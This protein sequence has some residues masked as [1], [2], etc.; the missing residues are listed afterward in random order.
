MAAQQLEDFFRSRGLA[1][2]ISTFQD[3]K[4][5]IAKIWYLVRQRRIFVIAYFRLAD[6]LRAFG[7][8]DK[9]KAYPE[10]FWLLFQFHKTE[11]NSEIILDL[12]TEPTLAEMLSNLRQ[13]QVQA[14]TYWRDF[15]CDLEDE[16]PARLADLLG[17]LT[18]ARSIPPLGFQQLPL[19][20]TF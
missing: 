9:I 8:L 15:V 13:K 17:F 3:E 16:D 20:S 6:G 11:L 14:I 7:L 4:R 1:H 19:T 2:L 5:R 12:Y 18:G 10:A